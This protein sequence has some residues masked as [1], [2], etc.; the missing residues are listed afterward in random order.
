MARTRTT[1]TAIGRPEPVII[2]D[3]IH[4]TALGLFA[5]VL[6][7]FALVCFLTVAVSGLCALTAELPDA[8]PCPVHRD[9]V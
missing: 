3:D 6:V 1:S 9:P 4:D 8:G 7:A 5:L 2:P